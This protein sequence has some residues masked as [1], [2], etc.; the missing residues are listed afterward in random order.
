MDYPDSWTDIVPTT[1]NNIASSSD[2]NTV[3]S[4]V[5]ALKAITSVCGRSLEHEITL[6]NLC[7]KMVVPLFELANKLFA[8]YTP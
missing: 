2:F 5:E 7:N 3:S 6:N 8:N 1:L 4:S